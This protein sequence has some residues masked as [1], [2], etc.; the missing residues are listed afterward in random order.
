MP[1]VPTVELSGSALTGLVVSDEHRAALAPLPVTVKLGRNIPRSRP[2]AYNLRDYV[3]HLEDLPIPAAVDWYTKAAVSIARMYLNDRYGCCVFSGKAHNLGVWSAND[4]DSAGGTTVVCTDKEISDQY[5]AYTGGYDNGAVIYEVLDYMKKP[6]FLASGK[7]YTIDGYVSVDWRSKELTQVALA[8]FGTGS[9]GINLPSAWSS[10]AV[11]DVTNTRIVGGHDVSPC[12]YG[13]RVIGTTADGV[14]VSSWGR[15]YLI[16][17]PAWVSTRWLDEFY[18]AIPTYLWTGA[19]RIAPSGVNYDQLKVDLAYLSNGDLPPLPPP[20]PTPPPLPPSPPVPVPPPTPLPPVPPPP[21]APLPPV[22]TG[23][24]V[25]NPV[26][27]TIPAQ[28]VTVRGPLGGSYSGVVPAQTITVPGQPITVSVP[29]TTR[30]N[31]PIPWA[32][33][34][35]LV[36]TYGR[37]ILPIVIAGIVAGKSLEEILQDILSSLR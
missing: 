19:D 29:T 21:P 12:G 16:T 5:F 1:T 9:I 34:V 36:L 25:V 35:Q 3:N 7:R 27:V 15:L 13:A 28:N 18:V 26:V 8:V 2:Q 23:T 30:V 17:W 20:T 22:L 31:A 4:P 11:W 24:G 32:V 33:I 6:G 37:Q 10:E 14:V